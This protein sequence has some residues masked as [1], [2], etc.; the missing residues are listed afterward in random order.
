VAS[1]GAGDALVRSLALVWEVASHPKANDRPKLKEQ[2][3]EKKK[4][5][6]E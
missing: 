2:E 1:L 4:R 5:K 3:K 6:R